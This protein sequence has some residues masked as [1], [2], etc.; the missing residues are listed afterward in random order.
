VP[1]IRESLEAAVRASH[2]EY[3][4]LHA[5]EYPESEMNRIGLGSA[6]S[7][8]KAAQK[9]A[10]GNAHIEL[11]NRNQALLNTLNTGG[12]EAYL[13]EAELLYLGQ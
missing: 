8:I 1:V 9:K 4:R 6:A 11:R 7:K 12:L 13:L 3:E 5:E 10:E 2:A